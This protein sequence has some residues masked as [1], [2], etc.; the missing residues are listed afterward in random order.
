VCRRWRVF[1]NFLEDMGERPDGLTL[2][3]IDGRGDYTPENCRWA[4]PTLQM[5]NKPVQRRSASGIKGV[6]FYKTRWMAYICADYK[7]IHLGC[8][9]T[10]EEAI[11][12]RAKGEEE[13]WCGK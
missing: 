10:K 11:E 3:R 12:A 8:F 6:R 2:D 4:T 7:Q 1:E 13:Y 9:D 5:R